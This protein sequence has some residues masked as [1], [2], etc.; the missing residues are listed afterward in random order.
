MHRENP[1]L[2]SITDILI[3]LGLKLG[4]RVK[5]RTEINK[6]IREIIVP[7]NNILKE[8]SFNIEYGK[9]QN[10]DLIKMI[11]G[12]KNVSLRNNILIKLDIK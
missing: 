2:K 7:K 9:N 1:Y 6:R 8:L 11:R 12:K 3:W 5:Y 10:N 4:K